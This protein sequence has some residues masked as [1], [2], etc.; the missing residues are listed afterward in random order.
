MCFLPVRSVTT[1]YGDRRPLS[2]TGF[3]GS[4]CGFTSRRNEGGSE[5]SH[6]V[7]SRSGGGDN[8]TLAESDQRGC[9]FE[10]I[11]HIRCSLIVQVQEQCSKFSALADIISNVPTRAR[12]VLRLPYFC[13]AVLIILYLCTSSE[14]PWRPQKKSNE[15]GGGIRVASG[16]KMM[17]TGLND[18]TAIIGNGKLRNH[19]AC[20]EYLT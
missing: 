1:S 13:V 6:A 20:S 5:R 4:A 3:R 7:R 16:S 12:C 9:E 10:T 17:F 14:V 11:C 18:R 2:K 15:T 19:S 8:S